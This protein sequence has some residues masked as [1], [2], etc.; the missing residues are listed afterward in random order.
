MELDF[1]ALLHAHHV[2][3]PEGHA[4]HG[5]GVVCDM[6][7]G[8]KPKRIDGEAGVHGKGI[9]ARCKPF[10]S[11]FSTKRKATSPMAVVMLKWR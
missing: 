11:V 7:D 3:H 5:H 4:R 6:V 10:K 2:L 9:K 1:P 8:L